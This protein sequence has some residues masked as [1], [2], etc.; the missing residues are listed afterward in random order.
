MAALLL[1]L[2]LVSSSTIQT[3]V[4]QGV[5]LSCPMAADTVSS[6]CETRECT[7]SG[8]G[9]LHVPSDEHTCL[10]VEYDRHTKNRRRGKLFLYHATHFKNQQIHISNYA[11]FLIKL[12]LALKRYR[13]VWIKP[14]L[15]Y[16]TSNKGKDI[17]GV[18]VTSFV[19][20]YLLKYVCSVFCSDQLKSILYKN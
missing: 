20:C 10:H 8:P 11:G 12:F 5:R 18:N 9:G 1:L 14:C 15:S 6:S 19:C 13:T 17:F 16:Q 2:P 3:S 4:G 7:W